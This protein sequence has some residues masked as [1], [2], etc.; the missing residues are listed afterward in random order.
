MR[1]RWTGNVA[2]VE[3]KWNGYSVWSENKKEKE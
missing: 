2:H 1:I 3:E